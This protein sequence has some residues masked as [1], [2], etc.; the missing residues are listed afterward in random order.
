VNSPSMP[1]RRTVLSAGGLALA[2][3]LAGCA[4]SSPGVTATIRGSGPDVPDPENA[5]VVA[6]TRERS[7]D[8][9]CPQGLLR[10]SGRVHERTRDGGPDELVLATAFDVITG[11]S[12]C[13][14]GWGQAGIDVTH[15]W[16]DGDVAGTLTTNGSNVVPTDGDGQATL[17]RR[18]DTTLGDWRVHLTPATQST[19]TY[20]FVS[21]FEPSGSPSGGDAL[22]QIRG[23]ASVEKGWF[24]SG[25]L[26]A[27]SVLT[28]G[29]DDR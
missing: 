9:G 19:M 2:S 29:Q 24:S 22:A 23:A 12:G 5:P 27:N 25:T 1:S 10:A 15:D 7:D 13:S 28:Y 20:G 21:R 18:H 3:G 16:G 14:S 17:E 6:R 8:D 4:G 26:G 11:E